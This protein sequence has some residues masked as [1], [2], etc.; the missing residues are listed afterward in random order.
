MIRQLAMALLMTTALTVAAAA[1][2]A[3]SAPSSRQPV[4]RADL[5][6][7]CARRDGLSLCVETIRSARR[8]AKKAIEARTAGSLTRFTRLA[9]LFMGRVDAFDVRSM[10]VRFN[11]ELR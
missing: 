7:D 1:Q 6:N 3:A 8:R 4:R 5:S 2:E 9:G 11:L 10:K